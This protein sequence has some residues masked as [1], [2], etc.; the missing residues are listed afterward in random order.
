MPIPSVRPRI[1]S[2]F[3]SGV[4]ANGVLGE[5]GSFYHELLCPPGWHF[6]EELLSSPAQAASASFFDGRCRD[7][8]CI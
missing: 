4:H 1:R 8:L 6:S 7:V 2:F 3:V 5:R